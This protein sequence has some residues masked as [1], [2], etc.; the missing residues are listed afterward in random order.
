MKMNSVKRI[1]VD[2]SVNLIHHGHVRLLEKA[3][4]LGSVIVG[5]T[6]D[7]EVIKYKGYVPELNFEQRKEIISS[8][9]QR[10]IPPMS[11]TKSW[12]MRKNTI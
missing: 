6:T 8:A 12:S 1:M 5:L 10:W 2:M 9:E 7:V 3:S 4:E 11:I